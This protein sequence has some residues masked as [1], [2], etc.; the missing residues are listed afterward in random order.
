[1]VFK[2]LSTG[3]FGSNTYI[4]GEKGKGV[5]IDAGAGADEII[6][7]AEK[8][9]LELT[10]VILT[11]GHIDHICNVDELRNKTGVSVAVHK[12]DAECLTD[13]ILNGSSFF[14]GSKAFKPADI[15]L[16]D[17]ETL[18]AGNLEFEIIHTPGHTRGGICIKTGDMVFTGDTLFRLSIG[19][20]DLPGGS[21]EEILSSIQ[22]K[23]FNLNENLKVYPGH[24]EPSTIGFERRNNPF[25][26]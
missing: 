24:G 17:G 22:N 5:V 26:G 7:V 9:K 19:R 3:M 10:H 8:N 21:M 2:C 6:S 13:H 1:M 20:T 16:N 18:V 11:H 12:E 23:L 4:I 25:F 15:L 14:I